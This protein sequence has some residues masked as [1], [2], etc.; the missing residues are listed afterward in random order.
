MH[1]RFWTLGLLLICVSLIGCSSGAQSQPQPTIAP[2]ALPAAT[3]APKPAAPSTQAPAAVTAAP[4]PA[5]PTAQPIAT[6]APKA[7]ATAPTTAEVKFGWDPSVVPPS[8]ADD[9]ADIT[10]KLKLTKGIISGT[11]DEQGYVVFYDSTVLTIPEIM[12]VLR[13]L[14]HPV[15]RK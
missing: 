13:K 5:V 4:K 9:V 12:D 1:Q 14:G 3:T 11:G 8:D 10:G 7:A 6:A 2:T 15:I